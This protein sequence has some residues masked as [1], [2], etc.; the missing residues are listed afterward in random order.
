MAAQKKIHYPMPETVKLD[1]S[2]KPLSL[3]QGKT[4]ITAIIE[5]TKT[6]QSFDVSK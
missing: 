1:F 4:R 5:R 6:T 2:D 3:Y